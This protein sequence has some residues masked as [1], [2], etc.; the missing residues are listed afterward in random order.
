MNLA[1]EY[2]K[3]C[4]KNELD[5]EGFWSDLSFRYNEP[6]RRYHNLIHIESVLKRINDLIPLVQSQGIEVDEDVIRFA[7]FYHDAVYVPNF[8]LN[9]RLSADMAL[10]HLAAQGLEVTQRYR[11][12]RVILDT[13]TH[14]VDAF[15]NGAPNEARILIDADLYELGTDNYELN[16]FKVRTEIAY[17]M[18]LEVPEELWR[19]GRRKFLETYLA[20]PR[21]FLL[22]GQKDLEVKA[23]SN[24]RDEL[25]KLG[26]CPNDTNGD[27][28]CGQRYCPFCGSWYGHRV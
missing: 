13:K 27:G 25:R 8:A 18:G 6:H 22:D 11:V 19:I 10:A 5:P 17:Y 24:M 3:L 9:E 7:A 23:R 16:K 20:R 12:H 4:A 15:R 26:G 14:V 2:A 1:I 21:L 28:D